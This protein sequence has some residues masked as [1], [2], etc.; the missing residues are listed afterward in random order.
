MRN[1]VPGVVVPDHV[2]ERMRKADADGRGREEGVR[3]AQETLEEVGAEIQGAQVSA[4][5][6]R[7]QGALDVLKVREIG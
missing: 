7:I 3:I 4:P 2:M 6:G 1:E 5:F